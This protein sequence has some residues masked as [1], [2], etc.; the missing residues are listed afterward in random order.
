MILQTQISL[1]SKALTDQESQFVESAKLE[2][3]R[4]RVRLSYRIQT[5]IYR[6]LSPN[7]HGPQDLLE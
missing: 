7:I 4:L 1:L 3:A 2:L 6:L 5:S